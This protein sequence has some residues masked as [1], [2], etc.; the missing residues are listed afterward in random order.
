M[1]WRVGLMSMI[2]ERFFNFL[3]RLKV[4]FDTYKIIIGLVALLGL[5]SASYFNSPEE[6]IKEEIKPEVAK[7][8]E[9]KDWTPIVERLIKEHVIEY[10]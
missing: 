10:H 6:P 1:Y 2:K 3:K 8:D 7:V 5:G 9:Q 4:L